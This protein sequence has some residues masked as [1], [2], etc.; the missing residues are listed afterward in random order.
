M[1]EAPQQPQGIVIN[2]KTIGAAVGIITILTAGITVINKVTAYEY[3]LN[4][5]EMNDSIRNNEIK[6]LTTEL[7]SLNSK[8]TDLT[9]E[10]REMRASQ[11]AVDETTNRFIK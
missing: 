1:A 7:K 8:L 10:L 9:I 4:Q 11:R 2:S 6:T 5:V 3:R